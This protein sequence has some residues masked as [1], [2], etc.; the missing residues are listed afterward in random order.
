MRPDMTERYR[1]TQIGRLPFALLVPA[2][3]GLGVL[4]A[5]SFH[6]S[7]PV[8]FLTLVVILA[9]FGALTVTVD[10]ERV[11]IRFGLGLV[12]RS[13]PFRRI[14]SVRA[15]RSSPLYG[16]GIRKIRGGW[17]YNVS[18]LQAVELE[19]N[20]GQKVRIGTDEPGE[21]VRVIESMEATGG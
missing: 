3:I 14:R 20:D 13:W 12:Q 8:V 15:V 9:T 7:L 10:A 5:V 1:H 17:L 11:R 2:L 4:M 21:L 6:W 16:W 19:L 18:G